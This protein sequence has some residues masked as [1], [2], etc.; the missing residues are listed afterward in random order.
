MLD[1]NLTGGTVTACT[2][3]S[4]KTSVACL[5]FIL[6]NVLNCLFFGYGNHPKNHVQVR[7]FLDTMFRESCQI[8]FHN[9]R[10]F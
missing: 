3:I 10:I 8:I 9:F 4:G 5:T 2:D 1:G 6:E 7:L